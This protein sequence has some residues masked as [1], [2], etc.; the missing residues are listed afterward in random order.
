MSSCGNGDRLFPKKHL[1]R[2]EGRQEAFEVSMNGEPVV[3]PAAEHELTLAYNELWLKTP[4]QNIA[5]SYKVIVETKMYYSLL[6]EFESGS[7]EEWQL[8]KR[9]RKLVRKPVPPIPEVI[10]LK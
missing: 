6:V 4:K 10:F 5:A 2:Y 1:G 9:G 3:V 7:V 8:W